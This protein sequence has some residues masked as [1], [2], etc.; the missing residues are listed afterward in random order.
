MWLTAALC[1]VFLLLFFAPNDAARSQRAAGRSI[2]IDH[3][4][5]AFGD[6]E[7]ERCHDCKMKWPGLRGRGDCRRSSIIRSPTVAR[8]TR[9]AGL[10]GPAGSD[11]A[12]ASRQV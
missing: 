11:G 6:R 7:C 8:V 4:G 9:A 12:L 3:I 10:K 2:C 5:L 1:F